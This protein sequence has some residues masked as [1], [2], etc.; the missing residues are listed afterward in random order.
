MSNYLEPL[1]EQWDQFAFFGIKPVRY[2]STSSDQFYWL[3]REVD[4]ETLPFY[5]FWK[6]SAFGS[7][8]M[9]DEQN[10]G[11]SLVYV[12]DWEA[13]CKLFIKTGKHRFNAYS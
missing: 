4:I 8:C 1:N 12:H 3:V 5:D 6:E 11:K 10:P 13:F 2:K 9:P 7:T